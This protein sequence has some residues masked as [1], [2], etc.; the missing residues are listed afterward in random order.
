MVA[1]LRLPLYNF[2]TFWG[3][4]IVPLLEG[5]CRLVVLV[6]DEELLHRKSLLCTAEQAWHHP[7]LRFISF[8]FAP[9]L[10]A[11]VTYILLKLRTLYSAHPKSLKLASDLGWEASNF[12]RHYLCLCK[13]HT[14]QLDLVLDHLALI[15]CVHARSVPL[16]AAKKKVRH[17][18]KSWIWGT[19][20]HLGVT[21][22]KL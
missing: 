21:H 22:I 4:R 20:F 3:A 17:P 1:L 15:H 2:I 14:R 7:K 13:N 18:Q 6:T 12:I 19:I 11:A 8:L 5:D 9:A 10:A 16:P